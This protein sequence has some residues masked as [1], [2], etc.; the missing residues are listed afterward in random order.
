MNTKTV[1]TIEIATRNADTVI[2]LTLDHDGAAFTLGRERHTDARVLRAQIENRLE[3]GD[4][5]EGYRIAV[6]VAADKAMR[7]AR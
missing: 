1:R 2:T 6:T 5:S 3:D 7:C 4:G